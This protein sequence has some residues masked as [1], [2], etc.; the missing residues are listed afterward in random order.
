MIRLIE[1]HNYRCLRHVRQ[2]LGN[3]HL[4]VGPNASGKTTFMDVFLFLSQLVS[5]DLKLTIQKRTDNFM[6]LVWRGESNEFELAA[7]FD[8]PERLRQQRRR[9]KE[10]DYECVRY[11]VRIGLDQETRESSILREQ[12]LLLCPAVQD[13]SKTSSDKR[14]GTVFSSSILIKPRSSKTL[15]S[16]IPGGKDSFTHEFGKTWNP[17]FKLG[18]FL[19][20]LGNAPEDRDFPVV[21]WL[22]KVLREGPSV[23]QLNS[24]LMQ[25]PSP[26]N[27]PAR[28]RPDGSN[29]PWLIESLKKNHPDRFQAWLKH[30]QTALSDLETIQIIDREEDRHRY[31]KLCYKGGVKCPSWVVS[32]GT[33]RLLALTLVAYLPGQGRTYFI[34]E[35]ENGL[36]PYVVDVVYQSL[37]S[38]YEDQVLAAT[39]SPVFVSNAKPEEI[40]CF[41][42]G[43]DQGTVIIPGNNHPALRNWKGEENLGVLYAGGVLG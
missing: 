23:L 13:K 6:D 40:L 32:D 42:A 15:V 28:L 35:P 41:R 12:V 4:L 8:I 14:N 34:E 26:P 9:A 21:S 38:I 2:P 33:L 37:S 5:D 29:L 27:Q 1:A 20:A 31:L 24:S 11:Q 36:H 30:L 18:P 39:H 19:S 3:F 22:K 43:G 17:Y 25:K 10:T 16:K 7:E